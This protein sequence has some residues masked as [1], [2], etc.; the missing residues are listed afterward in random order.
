V[1]FAAFVDAVAHAGKEKRGAARVSRFPS[2]VCGHPYATGL[3]EAQTT[4]FL[5]AAG[6]I[7][8]GNQSMVPKVPAEPRVRKVFKRVPRDQK[9]R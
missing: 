1:T 9:H 6:G 3:N 4:L 2:N 8:D 5:N 7:I